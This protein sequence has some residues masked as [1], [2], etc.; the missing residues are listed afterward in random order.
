MPKPEP[1][2][3]DTPTNIASQLLGQPLSESDA[4]AAAGLLTLLANDM[5]A[6]RAMQPGDEEPA[7]T[8][9]AV[10]GEP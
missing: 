3:P 2:T 4:A 8:Y 6:F 9:S 10:E 7:T 1:V 5:R